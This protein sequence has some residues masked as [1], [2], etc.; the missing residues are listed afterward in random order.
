MGVSPYHPPP[1]PMC[2][3]APAVPVVDVEQD[4]GLAH[5]HRVLQPVEHLAQQCGPAPDGHAVGD[6]LHVPRV[7]RLLGQPVHRPMRHQH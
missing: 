5:R 4:P 2:D 3:P 1:V 7:P 6:D